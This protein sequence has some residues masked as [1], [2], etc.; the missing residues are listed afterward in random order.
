MHGED[1][2]ESFGVIFMLIDLKFADFLEAVAAKTPTPGGGSVA[3]AVGGLGAALGVMVARYSEA[4]D[5]EGALDE[6]KNGFLP[7]VDQ[8]AEAYGQVNSAR[9][10]PKGTEEEK[11]RR[12]EALQNALAEASEAPRKG[13]A[14]AVRGLRALADLAPRCNR[15]LASDLAGAV[16]CLEAALAGCGENVRVNAA[17]LLDKDRRARLQEERM[18]LLEEGAALKA[19]ILKEVEVLHARK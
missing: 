2:F 4:A 11:K 14:L 1:R 7:L 16:S 19:R 5:A 9:L 10:L 12:K 6:V 17:A 15:H 8:D 18:R 13:M 3:A